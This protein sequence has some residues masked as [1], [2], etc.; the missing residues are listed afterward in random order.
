MEDRLGKERLH[1]FSLLVLKYS[2]QVIKKK[3][4]IYFFCVIL[5]LVNNIQISLSCFSS[6]S[7]ILPVEIIDCSTICGDLS[8]VQMNIIQFP[9]LRR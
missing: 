3:V 1:L 2:K 9:E 5:L 7:L 6:A 8:Q 4:L